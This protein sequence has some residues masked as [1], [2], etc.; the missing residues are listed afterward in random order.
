MRCLDRY[1]VHAEIVFLSSIEV[2]V[3]FVR[4]HAEI[5]IY[6]RMSGHASGRIQGRLTRQEL[7]ITMNRILAQR[8]CIQR[9]QIALSFSLR[10]SR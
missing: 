10:W 3:A 5:Q 7:C 6:V 2:D 1:F 9:H 4:R 8:A